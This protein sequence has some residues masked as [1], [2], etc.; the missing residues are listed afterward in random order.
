MT[1][2]EFEGN[3]QEWSTVKGIYAHSTVQAQALKAVAEMGELADS[4]IRGDSV[5]DDIGDIL[6]CLVNVATLAG[7]DLA[8]C[9]EVA[10]DEIK[11]RKG[12]MVPGG[13]FVKEAPED[14]S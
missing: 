9:A 7:T 11:D 14:A 5:D 2:E 10:W 4:I 6:V 3:V 13:A 12:Y 1:L 8:S